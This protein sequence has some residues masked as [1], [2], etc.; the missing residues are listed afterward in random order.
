M[1]AFFG[2]CRKRPREPGGTEQPRA[3]RGFWNDR[4]RILTRQL[5]RPRTG[6]LVDARP[7]N[8]GASGWFY[9]EW[10][11]ARRAPQFFPLPPNDHDI[12]DNPHPAPALISKKFR[13]YPTLDQKQ[14]L[15]KWFGVYR[16]TYNL[17]IA[18]INKWRA[19]RRLVDWS[20]LS[21]MY[22]NN[23]SKWVKT[24]MSEVPSSIRS[25]ACKEA[26]EAFRSNIAK[27]RA[28][29]E[30]GEA[31]T[32][33]SLSFKS[34]WAPQQTIPVIHADWNRAG[35]YWRREIGEFTC[36]NQPGAQDALSRPMDHDSKLIRTR[37]GEYFISIPTPL[38]PPAQ[39]HRMPPRVVALI[40]IQ[41][42]AHSKHSTTPPE[43]PAN[44]APKMT[45]TR[46]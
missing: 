24:W 18:K 38:Q 26:Y 40:W 15:A 7:P 22:V 39:H 36:S 32:R 1:W 16:R 25:G 6:M 13:I 2:C 21:Q 30:R 34:K 27:Q 17:C 29:R 46:S 12:G 11:R 3:R 4:A 45:A 5:W 14:L 44:G 23:S 8:I 33:F 37:L 19:A 20:M 43:W 28:Q 31:P 35:G 42:C 41:G 10:K 9:T